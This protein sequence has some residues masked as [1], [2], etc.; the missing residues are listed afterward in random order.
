MV[1]SLFFQ[2]RNEPFQ[3][4]ARFHGGVSKERSHKTDP[5][6]HRSVDPE[7]FHVGANGWKKYNNQATRE[8]KSWARWERMRF[9]TPFSNDPRGLAEKKTLWSP[10]GVPPFNMSPPKRPIHPPG[11]QCHWQLQRAAGGVPSAT[12]RFREDHLGAIP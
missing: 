5:N 8:E 7:K 2:G 3:K 10:P 1:F 4:T 12:L 9:A 11:G 6:Q